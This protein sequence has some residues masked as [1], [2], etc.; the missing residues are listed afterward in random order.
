MSKK[1]YLVR[2]YTVTDL[3]RTPYGDRE[4][5]ETDSLF[6]AKIKGRWESWWRQGDYPTGDGWAV[7][8]VHWEIV[9]SI[10][11]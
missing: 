2:T 7:S 10:G 5:C 8:I 9:N 1:K 4:V 3:G 6:W 11:V